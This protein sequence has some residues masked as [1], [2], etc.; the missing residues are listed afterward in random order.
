MPK[1]CRPSYLFSIK[2]STTYFFKQQRWASTRPVWKC[3]L[4]CLQEEQERTGSNQIIQINISLVQQQVLGSRR[5]GRVRVMMPTPQPGETSMVGASIFVL[6]NL[7][8][9]LTYFIFCFHVCKCTMCVPGTLRVQKDCEGRVLLQCCI[10]TGSFIF[11][12]STYLQ[13][14]NIK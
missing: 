10:L 11:H 8:F 2:K 1:I 14:D 12:K 6:K 4:G 9:R 13:S 5:G 3:I 7:F